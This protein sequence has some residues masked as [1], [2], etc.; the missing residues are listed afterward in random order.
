MAGTNANAVVGGG[1]LGHRLNSCSNFQHSQMQYRYGR[2]GWQKLFTRAWFCS[3]HPATY[4]AHILS[5]YLL[6]R[7]ISSN[8]APMVSLSLGRRSLWLRA[9]DALRRV[10]NSIH[11]Q[12]LGPTSP[13]NTGSF[14]TDLISKRQLYYR[15]LVYANAYI[16][17][18]FGPFSE[19]MLNDWEPVPFSWAI[20]RSRFATVAFILYH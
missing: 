6:W 13:G 7:S 8:K 5:T 9:V 11:A 19:S 17:V 20:Q 15:A 18:S 10:E 2:G 3:V 12:Q 4:P 14:A 16:L 1:I